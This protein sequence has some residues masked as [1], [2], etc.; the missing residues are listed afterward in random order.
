MDRERTKQLDRTKIQL[1]R[2]LAREVK[3]RKIVE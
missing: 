1:D 2:E 3:Q